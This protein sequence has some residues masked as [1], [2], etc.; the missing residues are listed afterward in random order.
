MNHRLKVAGANG[1]IFTPPALREVHRLSSGIPRIINVI[2]DRALLGA[3][4]QEQHRIG[5]ALVRDAAGEVYGRSFSPPWIKAAG[6]AFR[7]LSQS[8]V[9]ALGIWLLMRTN[10]REPAALAA[11]D[12]QR[13]QPSSPRR[14]RQLD[15][16][17]CAARRSARAARTSPTLLKEHAGETNTESAFAQLFALWGGKFDPA[18]GPAVRPGA[19]AGTGMRLSA[20][21][22]GPAAH[23]ESPGDPHADRRRRQRA[24]GRGRRARRRAM[25]KISLPDAHARR[26]D[27]VDLAL[28]VRR[29][30][31]AV[32]AAGCVAARAVGGHAGRRRALAARTAQHGAGRS[33]R[34]RQRATTTT[35]SSCR[36]WKI[37]SGSIG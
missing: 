3:F 1:E 22:V 17:P 34:R 18:A 13:L 10:G 32:A 19:A 21:L 29:L 31:G 11:D 25:R 28:L 33:Q 30:S 16:A 6:R 24:S 27:R 23:A 14:S 20:G 2:C 26:L 8:S 9:L 4:T 35:R 7:P 12:Q 5:P 36:W 37:F 15:V